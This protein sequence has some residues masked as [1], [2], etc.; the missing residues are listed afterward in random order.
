MAPICKSP[1]TYNSFLY[2]AL[3]TTSAFLFYPPLHQGKR[4]Q[5]V[6]IVIFAMHC[7][8]HIYRVTSSACREHCIVFRFCILLGPGGSFVLSGFLPLIFGIHLLATSG[9]DRQFHP[10]FVHRLPGAP[11][12]SLLGTFIRFLFIVLHDTKRQTLVR[13]RGVITAGVITK[14]RRGD[15]AETRDRHGACLMA[16]GQ[17]VLRYQWDRSGR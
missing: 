14:L 2:T 16:D 11:S 17:C 1:Y 12:L 9:L 3:R 5:D 8:E 10:T 7:P 15:V 6:L 4:R 13:S